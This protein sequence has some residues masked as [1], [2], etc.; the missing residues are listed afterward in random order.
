VWATDIVGIDTYYYRDLFLRR[1]VGEF[2][3]A[4]PYKVFRNP[5]YGV[6]HLHGYGSALVSA[7]L[8]GLVLVAINQTCVWMFYWTV[9]KPHIEAV[10]GKQAH[11]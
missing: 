8:L 11:E 1:P 3:V 9:E 7:S 4:G 6:G 10:Y 2:R 5:M